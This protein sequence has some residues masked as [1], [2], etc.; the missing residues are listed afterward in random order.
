MKNKILITVSDN[1]SNIKK[2]VQDCLKWKHFGCYAHNI[3][4]I[5]KGSL[6][7]SDEVSNLLQK[8]RGV[9]GHFKRNTTSYEKLLAYQANNTADKTQLKLIQD[10][11]TRWN[12]TFYMLQRFIVLEQTVKATVALIG[13]DVN[14]LS[15][16]EWKMDH[17]LVK[18]LNPF[19]T[20]T[21]HVSG[22]KICYCIIS[23]PANIRATR[24]L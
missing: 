16:E 2:A 8:V 17:A 9:V 14:Q 24:R 4:L 23:Y 18:V 12:S 11:P 20:V 19:E 3:N 22:K 5:V 21:K 7:F 13:K 1:A 6:E 10:V 15:S